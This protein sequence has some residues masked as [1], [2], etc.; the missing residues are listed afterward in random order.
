MMNT[1]GNCKSTPENEL[2]FN[3]IEELADCNDLLD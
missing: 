2:L 1:V 3:N